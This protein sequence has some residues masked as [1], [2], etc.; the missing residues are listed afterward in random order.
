MDKLYVIN[1][2]V[3][4]NSSIVVHSNTLTEVHGISMV[5]SVSHVS[6]AINILM[7]CEGTYYIK[8]CVPSPPIYIHLF[9]MF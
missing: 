6:I 9:P 4:S 8:G 1:L 3:I 7:I 2:K 5:I